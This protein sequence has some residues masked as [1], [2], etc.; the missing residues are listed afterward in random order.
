MSLPKGKQPVGC[1][2][3][4]TL[5]YKDDRSFE[6]YKARLVAKGYTQTYEVDYQE[7]FASLAKMNTV[8]ILLSIA[9]MFDWYL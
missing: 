2:W 6:R 7:A 3:V 1:K 4:Y 5:K 9:A 8:Q